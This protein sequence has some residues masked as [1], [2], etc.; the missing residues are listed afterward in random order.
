MTNFSK[1][2][3]R[4]RI[5]KK[6][7]E[8]INSD[9]KKAIIAHVMWIVTWLLILFVVVIWLLYAHDLPSIKKLSDDALPESVMIYDKK[10]NELY[11]LYWKEK[12][13]YVDIW[14]I[15]QTMKDAII[16]TEDKT[17]YKNSWFDFKWIV[18]AWA[19]YILWKTDR[20]Q[21]TSTISQQLIRNSFLTQERSIKR[22][23]QEI[24]LSY[25]LNS[26]FTKDKILELY[27]NKISYGSNAY[28]IEEASKT[29]F[30]KNAKDLWILESSI[31]ASIPKW[32]TYYSPYNHKDRLM[33][34]LYVYKENT[35]K[36]IIKIE[37]TENPNFYKPLKDKF[38]AIVADMKFEAINESNVKIC[39]LD[40]AFF[41]DDI[42]ID[43]N[44]CVKIDYNYLMTFLNGIQ[45]PYS[46]LNISNP[47]SDL[48]WYILEYNT[49]RKDFVLW[50]MLED[51]KIKND[52]YKNSLIA[53][54]DFQFKKYSEKIKYP[55]FVFYVKEYLENKYWKDFESQWGLKIYTTIDPNLQDKAEELVKKQVETNKTKY[56]AS[57][58]ALISLDNKTWQILAMVWWVDYFSSD[59]WSNVNIITSE[60]QPWS[61]F[62]PIVYSYA[63]S[64][65][66]IWPDTPIYDTD[67]TFAKWNPDNYD[68]K[69]MGRMSLRKAL[70]YSRNIP[71]V[72]IFFYAWWE[73]EIIKYANSLWIESLNGWSYYGW[74]LAIWTWEVKP[75]EL[76]QAYSVFANQW[77][78]KDI[79]PIL[80]I[81]DKKWNIIENNENSWKKWTQ[82][83]SDA[84]AY[85]ITTILSDPANRPND[86][87]NNVL[88]LKDRKVAAKTW[89]SNKDVTVKWKEKKILPSDLWTAWYTPQITT[90]VWAWNTD[91][92]PTK[93][94]CD[95]LN[96]AAPIWHSYMEYAHKW[97]PKETFDEPESV[98]HATISKSS[99]KL[100]W[101]STPNELKVSSIFAIKPTDYDS[102][103]KQ[104]QVDGLCNWA[105]S[106]LTPPEAIKTVYL[107]TSSAPIIDSYDKNWLK[108]IWGFSLDSWSWSFV[109]SISD[110]ICER[111]GLDSAWIM[112]STTLVDWENINWSK[113][114]VDIRFD[115]TNPIIKIEIS[116]DGQMIKTIPIDNKNWGNIEEIF[117]FSNDQAWT[118]K[119]TIK[120]VDKFY[121]SKSS[122]YS[123]NINQGLNDNFNWNSWT[124][125][126]NFTENLTLSMQ[127]PIEWD[128]DI[129][130]YNDQF[131]NLKWIFNVNPDA[132]NIY[133]NWSIFKIIDST[134]SFAIPINEQK[135]FNVWTYNIKVEWILWSTKTSK[136]ITLTVLSR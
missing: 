130:I 80:R 119:I 30:W 93:W 28:W 35:P 4:R 19:N 123:L 71:A 97:L 7:I 11:N 136:N 94:S 10:W 45:I 112:I 108:T 65:K 109:S 67:T 31:M 54:L 40:R 113:K 125:N 8:E 100:V 111:P 13:T 16:S 78:R 56:W 98:I 124:T 37:Q 20:I 39:K 77:V 32:P 3:L 114:N 99:W 25:Q 53:S 122:I 41:K 118:H 102:W 106:D 50:R 105:I 103:M 48:S 128:T 104:A 127:N 26:S 66:P 84:A 79:T 34:Y 121:Y 42:K 33:G 101:D 5:E 90:V 12:R 131:F 58:A 88:T 55:Y 126:E 49:W 92:S 120:A 76:A 117:D 83:L 9:D 134:K 133:L 63:I 27:L 110:A 95:W 60:K 69:Y 115:A 74:P 89:T 29:F 59:R 135:D 85:I 86:F 15:S 36:D 38:K 62:K 18:R 47:N 68:Q 24:Y 132:I 129:S 64:Q 21:W 51:L 96:C 6:R 14:N 116:K 43:D 61:S 1:E 52:D 70:W 72:K 57:N 73:N 22:K 75:L 81:E 46:K 87:W 44:W 17:F 82:V 107:W 91:W 23:A 2:E